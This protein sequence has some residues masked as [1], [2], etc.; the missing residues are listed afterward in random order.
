MYV[1][2]ASEIKTSNNITLVL[3]FVI[4]LLFIIKDFIT[5]LFFFVVVYVRKLK[6]FPYRKNH[7]SQKTL[8]DKQ[9]LLLYYV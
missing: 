2:M 9:T 4:Q 5:L 3:K 8:N 6:L 1:R 7:T